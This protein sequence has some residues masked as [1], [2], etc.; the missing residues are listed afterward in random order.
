MFER[1]EKS[2][3]KSRLDKESSQQ[4]PRSLLDSL[5]TALRS[6]LHE[7]DLTVDKAAKICGYDRRRLSRELH[8]LGTSLSKEIIRLRVDKASRQLVDTTHPVAEI[9]ESV[10]FTDPTIFSRAF[11]NWT[12]AGF[13]SPVRRRK[14]IRKAPGKNLSGP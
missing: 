13:S 2:H 7:S 10:G 9:A 5:R 6:H 1:F 14:G 11:K 4:I 8:K 12:G 3:F